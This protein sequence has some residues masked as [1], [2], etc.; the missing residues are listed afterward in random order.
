MQ[1]VP[2][3]KP[4]LVLMMRFDYSNEAATVAT[5]EL[6]HVEYHLFNRG[7]QVLKNSR[8]NFSLNGHCYRLIHSYVIIMPFVNGLAQTYFV[9]VLSTVT[10]AFSH[11]NH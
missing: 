3:E 1:S 10:V 5:L 2:S 11:L 6:R 8:F 9:G 4:A 7:I